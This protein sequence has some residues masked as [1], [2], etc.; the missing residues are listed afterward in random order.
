MNDTG[1]D[2]L[3]YRDPSDPEDVHTRQAGQVTDEQVERVQHDAQQRLGDA[4]A[5]VAAAIAATRQALNRWCEVQ[6][7]P[8]ERARVAQ[9]ALAHLEAV[10]DRLLKAAVTEGLPAAEVARRVGVRPQTVVMAMTRKD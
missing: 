5:A 6:P 7:D 2:R 9:L 4:E 3:P 10:R 1:D 8:L